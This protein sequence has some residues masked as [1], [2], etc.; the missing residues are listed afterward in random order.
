[1]I[2]PE[3]EGRGIGI[4]NKITIYNS[5]H[6]GHD[7]VDAQYINNFPNDLRNYD[8]LK[9]IFD[10]YNVDKIRLITNNPQKEI[11]VEIA[12]RELLET[13]KIE[14]TVNEYNRSYLMTKMTKNDHN[15]SKEFIN[16]RN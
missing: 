12:G 3:E 15:F 10:V 13:V 1:M 11:A 5:Q 9:D 14:S 6:A 2:Y 4:L 8:Y 7:T 16:E